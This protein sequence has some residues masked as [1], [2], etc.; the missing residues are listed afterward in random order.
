MRLTT[1][2]LWSGRADP[3]ALARFLDSV[4]PDVV[5]AQEVGTDVV[6]VLSGSHPH[7][8]V[9]GRDDVMGRA[10]VATTPIEVHDLPMP[11]RSGLRTTVDGVRVIA[12]HLANPVDGLASVGVRRR[13]VDAVLGEAR[14]E[15]RVVVVGDMNATPIWPAYRRLRR[16]LADGV[17]DWAAATGRRPSRTWSKV[18]YGP[19]LL[20]IDHVLTRGMVVTDCRV[21]RVEG[22]DHFAVTVDVEAA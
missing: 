6:D 3:P 8:V 7:G 2:N 19:A 10:L 12:V 17:A 18:P 15:H 16:E 21:D 22:S 11:A 13:Q 9:E 4:Q 14:G 1:V 20:R 5:A